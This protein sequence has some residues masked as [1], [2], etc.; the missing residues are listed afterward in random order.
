MQNLGTR[1]G[2]YSNLSTEFFGK[3]RYNYTSLRLCGS[4]TGGPYKVASQN[5]QGWYGLKI[6][7]VDPKIPGGHYVP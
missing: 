4:A 7:S 1:R 6:G 5:E 2:A 3:G